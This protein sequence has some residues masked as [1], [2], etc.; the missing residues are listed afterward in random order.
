MKIISSV[1]YQPCWRMILCGF[2]VWT[3]A[4]SLRAQE[5]SLQAVVTPS[6]EIVKGGRPVTFAIHGFIEFK[7]LAKVFPYI[8][9]E[10]QRWKGKISEE[11]RQQLAQ[12][13]LREGIESRVVSMADERPLQALVTHTS[14][15]VRQAIARVKEPLPAGYAEEFL[16]VQEKWKHSLNGWSASPV[17]CGA[18]AVELVSD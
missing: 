9:A 12:H 11:G 18:S 15:E 16:A 3:M 2:L 13:L 7:S 8:E 6:T 14:E 10:T 5:L 4:L 17:I 1:I